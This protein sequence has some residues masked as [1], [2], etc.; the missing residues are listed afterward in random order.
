MEDTFLRDF[1]GEPL[2]I[3]QL[4]G[5]Y[6]YRVYWALYKY[7]FLYLSSWITLEIF[8]FEVGVSFV[9]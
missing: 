7:T 6:L 9:F 8:E 3:R 2:A 1:S 5:L 4:M